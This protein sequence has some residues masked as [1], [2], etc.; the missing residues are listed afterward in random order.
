MFVLFLEQPRTVLFLS[1]LPDM[2][3]LLKLFL[4]SCTAVV[5]LATHKL[6]VSVDA[7]VGLKLLATTLAE[8]TLLLCGQI[9]CWLGLCKYLKALSQTLQGRTL[10]LSCALSPHTALITSSNNMISLTTLL[11]KAVPCLEGDEADDK[12]DPLLCLQLNPISVLQHF[13]ETAGSTDHQHVL[14]QAGFSKNRPLSRFFLVVAMSV[15][16]SVCLSVLSPCNYF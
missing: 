9:L 16:L 8:N 7:V 11:L 4:Y 10:S 5:R 1:P 2:E 15:C 14:R 3:K 12:A 6:L 13:F